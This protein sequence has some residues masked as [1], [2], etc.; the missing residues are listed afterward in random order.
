MNESI[1]EEIKYNDEIKFILFSNYGFWEST[2]SKTLLDSHWIDIITYNLNFLH[3]GGSS[4][5][6]Q[7]KNLAELNGTEIRIIFNKSTWKDIDDKLFDDSF[8]NHIACFQSENNHAKL[9]LSKNLAYIGSANYSKGS[10]NNIESGVIIT[11]SK[12]INQLRRNFFTTIA[13]KSNLLYIPK[14]YNEFTFIDDILDSLEFIENQINRNQFL[15]NEDNYGR[16]AELRYLSNIN[17]F[18]SKMNLKTFDST[19][20]WMIFMKK[21]EDNNVAKEDM[22]N[23]RK[24]S[25]QVEFYL[26]TLK[27]ELIKIFQDQGGI[28][29]VYGK[30]GLI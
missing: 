14:I 15:N 22:F 26:K 8:K 5:Y 9:F 27:I 21:L 11:N 19:Y 4:V 29:E 7:L 10:N 30:S 13:S 28:S 25:L 3:K 6:K 23:F 24:Y 1:Y 16:I 2:F 12:M 18:S 20:N 17:K